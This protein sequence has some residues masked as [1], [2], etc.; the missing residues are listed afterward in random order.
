MTP[1]DVETFVIKQNALPL[2]GVVLFP[3]HNELKCSQKVPE[4]K[5]KFCFSSRENFK[6]LCHYS[7]PLILYISYLVD[8]HIITIFNSTVGCS[9][10]SACGPM[11]A[12][13][14][15]ERYR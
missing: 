9:D 14:Q 12:V 4:K 10:L 13:V 6:N 1:D 11:Y 15:L 3:T 7:L 5:G 8:F 2:L